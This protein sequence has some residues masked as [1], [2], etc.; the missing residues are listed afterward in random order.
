MWVEGGQSELIG[1]AKGTGEKPGVR[2]GARGPGSGSA[3]ETKLSL[4]LL[5]CT[6][7]F[8]EQMPLAMLQTAMMRVFTHKSGQLQHPPYDRMPRELTPEWLRT[9]LP[10]TQEGKANRPGLQ[11]VARIDSLVKA[12]Y[13]GNE[14]SS[15]MQP[16]AV[17]LIRTQTT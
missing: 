4:C 6:P 11:S 14:A 16:R 12:G 5:L 1:R 9:P 3:E 2:A 17:R 13:H 7:T 15:T 8:G 10:V